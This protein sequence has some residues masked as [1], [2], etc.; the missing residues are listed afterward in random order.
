MEQRKRKKG[1]GL[2]KRIPYDREKAVRYAREWALKRN[3]RYLNF[4]DMGGDCTNFASQC[5]FAGCGQMNYTP[6]TGWYYNRPNDRT[7]SWTGVRFLADFLLSN[8]SSGPYA[9]ETDRSGLAPGD[10]VQLGSADGVYYHTPIV[11]SVSAEGIFVAAHSFDAYMRP[12]QSYSF[13][14]LRCFHIA[15]AGRWE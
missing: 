5:L 3:P 8:R 13:A 1:N 2:L 6:A 4:D 11:T 14:R 12:L 10:L 15:G 9:E 7:A